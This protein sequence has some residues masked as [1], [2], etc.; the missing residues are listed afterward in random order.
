MSTPCSVTESSIRR[1]RRLD[2]TQVYDL[3]NIM[4]VLDVDLFMDLI[5]MVI[6]MSKLL[7]AMVLFLL[8]YSACCLDFQRN[9]D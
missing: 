6:V 7:L 3:L 1:I 2:T 8:L 9:C 5:Q 4:V